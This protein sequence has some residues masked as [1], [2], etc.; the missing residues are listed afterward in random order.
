MHDEHF[1]INMEQGIWASN[2]E[3]V[4]KGRTLWFT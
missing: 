2:K 3:H 4:I 1:F